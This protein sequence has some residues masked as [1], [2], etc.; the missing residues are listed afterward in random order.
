[1]D[2][3]EVLPPLSILSLF[4]NCSMS[5]QDSRCRFFLPMTSREYVPRVVPIP[6]PSPSI[7]SPKRP[8]FTK[9]PFL[10]SIFFFRLVIRVFSRSNMTVVTPQELSTRPCS[11]KVFLPALEFTRFVSFPLWGAF[12]LFL[13]ELI[14]RIL[15]SGVPCCY[16]F[17]SSDEYPPSGP[18][19]VDG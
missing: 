19:S 6:I 4:T 2:R 12:G 7:L 5:I 8:P 9:L 14:L 11:F 13:C 16:F 15:F 18:I 10:L 17:F 1:V 3:W